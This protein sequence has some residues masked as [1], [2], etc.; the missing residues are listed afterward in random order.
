MAR[1]ILIL[2]AGGVPAAMDRENFDQMF[3]RRTDFGP[4]GVGREAEPT[5]DGA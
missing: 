1:P 5:A 4:A 3:P 2:K